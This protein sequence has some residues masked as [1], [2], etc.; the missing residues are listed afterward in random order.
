MLEEPIVELLL[1]I[2]SLILEYKHIA[3]YSVYVYSSYKAFCTYY[4]IQDLHPEKLSGTLL[5]RCRSPYELFKCL[6][7]SC[8]G[9]LEFLSSINQIGADNISQPISVFLNAMTVF[10]IIDFAIYFVALFRTEDE[11][12]SACKWAEFSDVLFVTPKIID[13]IM[14]YVV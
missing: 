11:V 3:I 5:E 10:A 1:E 2:I 12:R 8:A 4:D 14:T 13:I 9:V 6:I 7:F